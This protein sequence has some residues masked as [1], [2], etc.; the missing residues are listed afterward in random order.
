MRGSDEQNAGMFSYVV[1]EARVRPDH[2]LRPIRRMT[3]EVFAAVAAVHEDVLRH[4]TIPPPPLLRALLPQSLHDSQRAV[5]DGRD[6]LQPAVSLVYWPRETCRCGRAEATK[7]LPPQP[8]GCP[9][10]AR[11]LFVKRQDPGE[12]AGH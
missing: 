5:A 4:R 12:V 1:P 3:D 6:R 9:P 11:R 8:I 7:A 2:P 10:I